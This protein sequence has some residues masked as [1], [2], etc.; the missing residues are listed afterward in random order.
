[1]QPKE[2]RCLRRRGGQALQAALPGLVVSPDAWRSPASSST[3]RISFRAIDAQSGHETGPRASFSPR[4]MLDNSRRR[5]RDGVISPRKR[6][7]RV[8]RRAAP[9]RIEYNTWRR[10]CP[11]H[12]RQ[13]RL[14]P[15]SMTQST[16]WRA[17]CDAR[18]RSKFARLGDVPTR[19][20]FTRGWGCAFI[21]TNGRLRFDNCAARP[22]RHFVEDQ[23]GSPGQSKVLRLCCTTRR[24]LAPQALMPQ[25]FQN[26]R[27]DAFFQ[28]WHRIIRSAGFELAN[29]RQVQT[30]LPTFSLI[31]P[32][33]GVQIF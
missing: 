11:N 5:Y 26:Q 29:T 31:N 30:R 22:P 1:M 8:R 10:F 18:S 33:V 12:E 19:V 16:T 9:V 14:S 7:A 27:S 6:A 32:R 17:A 13:L 2:M 15:E 21:P 4:T 23:T 20:R 3:Q 25:R 24:P 28:C